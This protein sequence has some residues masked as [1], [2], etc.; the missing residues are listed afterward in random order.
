LLLVSLFVTIVLLL[1]LIRMVLPLFCEWSRKQKRAYHRIKSGV[2]VAR[3]K[4][5]RIHHLILTSSPGARYRNIMNDFQTLRKRVLRKFGFLM[6]YCMVHTNEGYGVLH[7]LTTGDYLP[8]RWLSDQW[9][10]IHLSPIVHIKNVDYD[11]ARYVV[12]QYV[13]NQGSSFQRCSW[14]HNWVCKG[15]VAEWKRILFWARCWS[16]TWQDI[17]AMWYR[18]LCSVSF[19]QTK[20]TLN[21]YPP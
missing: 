9:R 10:E 15:F 2:Q 5:R 21:V 3:I 8:Q 12:S 14:S 11:L 13:A 19:V 20:L 6:A 4:K 1:T 16:K 7:V 17:L 18:Y